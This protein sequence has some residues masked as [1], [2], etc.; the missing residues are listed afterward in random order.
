MQRQIFH[1]DNTSTPGFPEDFPGKKKPLTSRDKDDKVANY[2]NF[3]LGI[4]GLKLAINFPKALSLMLMPRL[5]EVHQAADPFPAMLADLFAAGAARGQRHV[6]EK[7]VA[8]GWGKDGF[9]PYL[10]KKNVVL[11]MFKGEKGWIQALKSQKNADFRR[12]G[13]SNS[14]ARQEL[15]P[16][17]RSPWDF[18]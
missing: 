15:R 7:Q 1:R 4:P 3:V 5:S 6:M 11:T 14:K 10:R 13:G 16:F 2:S 8:S 9:E 18:R 17:L 12:K